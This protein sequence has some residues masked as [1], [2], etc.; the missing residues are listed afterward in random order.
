MVLHANSLSDLTWFRDG[1]ACQLAVRFNL[2]PWWSR[3]PT[4]CAIWR[5]SMEAFAPAP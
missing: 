4:R 3:M 2:V 5:W 1:P